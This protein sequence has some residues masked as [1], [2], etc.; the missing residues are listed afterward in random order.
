MSFSARLIALRKDKGLTQQALADATHIHVQQIKRYEAGTSEPSA[1]ALRKIARTFS[2][3]T[4]WLLFEE[5]ERGPTDDLRLQFE[6]I[7]HMPE[8][9]RHIVKALLEGMI[10]KYQTKQMVNNLSS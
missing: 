10:L 4:D 6:A 5:G 8:E 1:E 2:I 9:E 3:S 7:S